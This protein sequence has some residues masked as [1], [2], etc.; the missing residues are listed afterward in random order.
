MPAAGPG[1]GGGAASA[2]P[3]S[4]SQIVGPEF[5]DAV[6]SGGG[7]EEGEGEGDGASRP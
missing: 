7:E 6:S 4:A 5:T 2:G 3:E 1:A